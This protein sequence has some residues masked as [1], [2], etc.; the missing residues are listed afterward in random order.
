MTLGRTIK[1][2]YVDYAEYIF[3]HGHAPRGRGGWAFFWDRSCPAEDA[4]GTSARYR[5]RARLLRM[6]RALPG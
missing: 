5:R 3:S 2:V 1:G 6:R 4:A